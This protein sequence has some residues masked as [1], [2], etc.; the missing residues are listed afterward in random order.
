MSAP[1]LWIAI[2]FITGVLIFLIS[3][4]RYSAWV[5]G[6]V[7]AILSLIAFF[8]PI[9]TALLIGNVSIKI[10]PAIQFF[11]RSFELNTADG[12]LL[13]IIYGLASLWF[14]YCG[15]ERWLLNHFYM[16]HYC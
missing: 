16:R 6:S 2:P 7:S 10:A 8:I 15:R 14:W 5:G 13:A 11:G 3:S 9:D 12:L 1:I 4:E